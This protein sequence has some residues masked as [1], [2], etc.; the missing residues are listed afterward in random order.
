MEYLKLYGA[1]TNS[2]IVAATVTI[3]CTGS[4]DLLLGVIQECSKVEPG[5][6]L[7]NSKSLSK[8]RRS[9]AVI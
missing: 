9:S 7:C 2:N 3:V 1:L 8:Q 4:S 5:T 6:T